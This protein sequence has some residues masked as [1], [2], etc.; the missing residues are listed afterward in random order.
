MGGLL[1]KNPFKSEQE[2]FLTALEQLYVETGLLPTSAKLIELKVIK[3]DKDYYRLIKDEFV[4]NGLTQLGIK[5]DKDLE[6]L[7]PVQLAAASIMMDFRDGRSDIKKLRDLGINSQTWEN[8]LRDPAFQN[9][10]RKRTEGLLDENAYEIDKALFLKARSGNVEAIKYVYA[11]QGKNQT[12]EVPKIGQ[13][14]AHVFVMR[15]F[16]VLQKHLIKQPELLQAIGTDILEIQNPYMQIPQIIDVV[17]DN[18]P[19]VINE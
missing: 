12:V 7:T 4:Q 13:V 11:I 6:I 5:Y 16:E 1:V 10:L 15:L 19:A 17:E 14:D 3:D 8:W 9:Y 18:L 2:K